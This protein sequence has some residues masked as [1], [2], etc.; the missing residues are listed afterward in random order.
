MRQL[1]RECEI[2]RT[3]TFLLRFV[4]KGDLTTVGKVKRIIANDIDQ[5]PRP[6]AEVPMGLAMYINEHKAELMLI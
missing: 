1:K 4:T 5:D 2:Q 6:Y 3:Y